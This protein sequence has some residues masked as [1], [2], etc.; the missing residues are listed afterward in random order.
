MIKTRK[1]YLLLKTVVCNLKKNVG[2][3][4]KTFRINYHHVKQLNW[5]SMGIVK[6]FFNCNK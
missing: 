1:F 2:D 3:I 5:Y 4:S 6:L